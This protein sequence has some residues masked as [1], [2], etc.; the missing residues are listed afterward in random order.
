MC[1]VQVATALQ[2]HLCCKSGWVSWQLT[3][4]G[5]CKAVSATEGVTLGVN[6]GRQR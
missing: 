3:L 1:T 5:Y 2:L 6:G 4:T